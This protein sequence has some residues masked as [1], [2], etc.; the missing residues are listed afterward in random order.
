ME[1]MEVII[2]DNRARIDGVVYQD[3]SDII[4]QAATEPASAVVSP[5]NS[6]GNLDGGIDSVYRKKLPF[7]QKALWDAICEM[8][9]CTDGGLPFLPVGCSIA[10]E[11]VSDKNYPRAFISA[12]TMFKPS[13]VPDTDNAFYAMRAAMHIARYM[14]IRKL[15]TPLMCTGVGKMPIEKAM[16]QMHKAIAMFKRPV[17]YEGDDGVSLIS[18][19]VFGYFC[20]NQLYKTIRLSQ[21]YI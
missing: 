12:P 21:P 16:E 6:W 2:F 1:R 20:G 9:F 11:N 15:Y 8:G 4:V 14:D 18:Q 3:V 7:A 19:G 5:S 17:H 13:K 10:L